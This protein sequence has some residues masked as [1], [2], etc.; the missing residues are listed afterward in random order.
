VFLR[1]N[2]KKAL[3]DYFT[4][5]SFQYRSEDKKKTMIPVKN[6][7]EKKLSSEKS[8]MTKRATKSFSKVAQE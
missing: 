6:C 1:R 2:S 3:T 4:Q 5:R 8:F 7:L